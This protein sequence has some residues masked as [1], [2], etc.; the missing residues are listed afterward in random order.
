[1]YQDKQ[2]ILLVLVDTS[3]V[4]R[5]GSVGPWGWVGVRARE[6]A[7]CGD[8]PGA[9]EEEDSECSPRQARQTANSP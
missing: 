2:S 1:M 9:G 6:R 3:A 5:Q 7:G 4:G 8:W